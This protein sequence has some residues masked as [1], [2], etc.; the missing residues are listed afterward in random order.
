M[1]LYLKCHNVIGDLLASRCL[2]SKHVSYL[3]KTLKYQS[4]ASMPLSNSTIFLHSYSFS[5]FADITINPE[6]RVVAVGTKVTLTC[7]ASGADDLKYQWMRM[8]KKTIPSG[9]RGTGSNQLTIPNIMVDDS[10]LYKCVISSGNVNVTSKVGNVSVLSKLL[11]YVSFVI[12]LSIS[13]S[14]IIT[15]SI[16][17][18]ILS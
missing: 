3:N 10:G 16:I 5:Y 18:C 6:D 13:I 17:M 15:S 4:T 9:A 8:G 2:T 11:I 7:A 1:Q 14:T 12:C